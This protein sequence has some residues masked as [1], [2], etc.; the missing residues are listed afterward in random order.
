MQNTPK[1]L[2][3]HIAIMGKRNVGKSSL[4]NA[5]TRQQ[6]AIVSE[7][8]G[9]TTDPVEK[10]MELFPLGPV[11]FIDTAGI[12]D[13]G[14]IGHLR[15]DRSL[16]VLKHSDIVIVTTEVSSWGK[17]EKDLINIIKK[18]N[19]PLIVAIN[20]IDLSDKTNNISQW[21]E[22]N[23]IYYI[24]TSAISK[25]GISGLRQLVID[26]APA[27]R[28]SNIGLVGDI[29]SPRDLILMVGPLDIEAPVGRLKLPQVQLI[30][31]CLDHNACCLMIKE[32][33]LGYFL[34]QLTNPPKMVVCESQVLAKV[35]DKIPT[36]TLL[37]TFSVILARFKG[38]LE[39][40][41]DGAKQ[42]KNL[43]TGD[44]VLIAEA[45]THPPV[46]EDIGTVVLPQ[47]I[48][49]RVGG[50]ITFEMCSGKDFRYSDLKR[51]KL[52][53]HC[54]ACM[55]NRQELISR[56]KTAQEQ[57]VAIT[58]YGLTIAYF[59]NLLDRVVQPFKKTN[60]QTI[61]PFSPRTQKTDSSI[62]ANK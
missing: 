4:L 60:C 14:E 42:L 58:N 46:G 6:A 55:L 32:T 27:G 1:S 30:R 5:L 50:K 54:G 61:S 45:C 40:F 31:N 23:A 7:F 12:D 33:E 21:L 10:T 26:S 53:I 16:R 3:T 20:K 2:R 49:E 39:I 34:S 41:I 43:K 38:E 24:K 11:V 9:T 13:K 56:T 15:V 47:L 29:V 51:Y 19:I 18:R 62:L 52:V 48:N 25:K 8:P 28:F 57:K 22:K 35:A 36:G 17:Y 59:N 37:T 44:K